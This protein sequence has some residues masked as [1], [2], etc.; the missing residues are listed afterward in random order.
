MMFYIVIP[1]VW[2]WCSFMMW[3]WERFDKQLDMR[4]S[5]ST[6]YNILASPTTPSSLTSRW[7]ILKTYGV[8]LHIMPPNATWQ[9]HHT[10]SKSFECI[11]Y[12]LGVLIIF[13]TYAPSSKSTCACYGDHISTHNPWTYNTLN[14]TTCLIKTILQPIRWH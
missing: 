10:H 7:S 14:L 5:L 12:T 1:I 6:P 13:P 11:V 9:S 2:F 3:V 4:I 8:C